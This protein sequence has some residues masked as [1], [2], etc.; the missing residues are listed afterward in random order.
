V[1]V[2]KLIS[3]DST[4]PEF[5]FQ[6]DAQFQPG[7]RVV[8]PTHQRGSSLLAG[9]SVNYAATSRGSRS[10]VLPNHK[11]VLSTPGETLWHSVCKHLSFSPAPTS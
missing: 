2:L 10:P 9:A 6:G 1:G 4:P 11:G 8:S 5:H 3:A 7:A